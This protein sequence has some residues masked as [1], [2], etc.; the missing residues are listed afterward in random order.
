[1]S[2]AGGRLKSLSESEQ[3]S[4]TNQKEL[5][6]Y[7]YSVELCCSPHD[8][9]RFWLKTSFFDDASFFHAQTIENSDEKGKG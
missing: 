5:G 2:W 4:S 1:M 3:S 9:T 6:L 7:P 8:L